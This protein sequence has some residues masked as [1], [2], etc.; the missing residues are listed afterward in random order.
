MGDGPQYA[1][2][3]CR[4]RPIDTSN[5][6]LLKVGKPGEAQ[7]T[8]YQCLSYPTNSSSTTTNQY[9]HMYFKDRQTERSADVIKAIDDKYINIPTIADLA[10]GCDWEW[11]FIYGARGVEFAF[12]TADDIW[13]KFNPLN[14]DIWWTGFSESY[15]PEFKAAQ[16]ERAL[17]Q[18]P[19]MVCE[20][21]LY[22]DDIKTTVEWRYAFSVEIEV[23]GE[24]EEEI[25]LTGHFINP[26]AVEPYWKDMTGQAALAYTYYED[27][28]PYT[29]K[30]L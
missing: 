6:V 11:R 25:G 15:V 19:M 4:N 17:L 8:A 23:G 18:I 20:N 22:T 10:T 13:T 1:T 16:F 5:N 24:D 3:M 14:R 30:A 7:S 26:F 29:H 2:S 21:I 28:M 12:I 9:F 27:M